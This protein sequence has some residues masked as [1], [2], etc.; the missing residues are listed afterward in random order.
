MPF[1]KVNRKRFEDFEE[2]YATESDSIVLENIGIVE[3]LES[4]KDENIKPKL[5]LRDKIQVF[6]RFKL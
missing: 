3:E 2:V 1:L 5:M 4:P 6:F